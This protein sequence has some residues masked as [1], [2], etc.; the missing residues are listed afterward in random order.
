[1]PL[2]HLPAE[3]TLAA[4]L[5]LSVLLLA[6]CRRRE[7]D[8]APG[9]YE[10]LHGGETRRGAEGRTLQRWQAGDRRHLSCCLDPAMSP[11]PLELRLLV[12]SGSDG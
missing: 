8:A 5:E 7:P 4:D 3:G 10:W 2:I 1:M 6:R 12:H 9:T 11:C